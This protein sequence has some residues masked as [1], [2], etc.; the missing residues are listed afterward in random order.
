MFA[1]ISIKPEWFNAQY[2]E[3]M[4]TKQKFWYE[5]D[6]GRRWLF[7]YNRKNTG[8]DWAEKIAEYLCQRLELPHATYELATWQEHIGCIAQSFLRTE[9]DGEEQQLFEQLILGSQL[10][11]A[12]EP[13]YLQHR[14]RYKNTLHNVPNILLALKNIAPPKH[15]ML[16][17]GIHT[18]QEVFIG[19]LLLDALIGNGDRHD[20]NWAGVA[21]TTGS[22]ISLAPTFDH[23]SSLGRELTDEE[24][25]KRLSTKDAGYAVENYAN[26]AESALYKEASAT[27]PLGT[28]EAFSAAAQYHPNAAKIWLS[29]L[30]SVTPAIIEE[31]FRQIP[32]HRISS[33]SVDF[34]I[35]ILLHNQ[36]RLQN[37]LQ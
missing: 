32:A 18:A 11:G 36:K 8:E 16:P 13:Q 20:E 9:G 10:L 31:G 34:A 2:D 23:A 25:T 4:G 33:V 37:T 3:V 1:E 19:Y 29:L 24:R 15:W 5:D 21:E 22:Q 28:V 14:T 27:K 17:Q 6:T 30:E 7:K 26:R 12:V 35:S